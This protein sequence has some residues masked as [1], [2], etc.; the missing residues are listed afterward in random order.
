MTTSISSQLQAI[1]SVIQTGLESKKRPITRPSILFDSKEAADLDIDTILDIALS[2]L[3]LPHF[4]YF[5][6]TLQ[7]PIS[8]LL[9]AQFY[10]P[11]NILRRL[12]FLKQAVVVLLVFFSVFSRENLYK[13]SFFLALGYEI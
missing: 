13:V 7:V 11:D 2:G 8:A 6:L 1:R 12:W 5:N 9:F 10:F 3:L 4:N